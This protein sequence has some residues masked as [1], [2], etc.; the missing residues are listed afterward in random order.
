MLHLSRRDKNVYPI[1]WQIQ[2]RDFNLIRGLE[3]KNMNL[4]KGFFYIVEEV[5]ML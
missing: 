3:L 4:R 1:A 5:G 2:S